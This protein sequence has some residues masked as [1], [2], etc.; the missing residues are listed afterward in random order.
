MDY[1]PINIKIKNKKC[2][3][4]GAGA[5]A[6]RKIQML[7]KAGA[8]IVCVALN[9]D[10]NIQLM[11]K[12][13]VIIKQDIY[14]YVDD[15]GLD[16]YSLIISA[17]NDDKLAQYIFNLAKLKN[18]LV[19]TVDNKQLCNYISPAIVDRNPIIISI[20]SSGVAPVL[21]RKIRESIEKI[22]P[23]KLGRLAQYAE[24][25]REQV[26]QSISTML[27]RRKFWESFFDST[28]GSKIMNTGY[29][30]N[31]NKLVNE[32]SEGSQNKGEVF[33]VGAG[34]GDPE[35][36]T[37]KAL[38][39]MQQA[40]VV[41]Y[42]RLISQEIIDL[43]RRDAE[44]INVGKSM[45]N[46]M[47]KQ[48][49]TNQL[50]IEQ[51]LK[52]KRV[53]RLKGGDP[54]VFGRGGEEIQALRKAGISYQIV[55]GITAAIGCASYAGIPLTH[56]DYAQKVVFVTAHCKNS[57]D[58]LDWSSIAQKKQTLVV[59]MGLMKS[60][61]LV[62]NLIANGQN[63]L[64]DVAVVENGTCHNQRVFNGRLYDLPG[65]IKRNSIESPALLIIGEVAKLGNELAWFQPQNQLKSSVNMLKIA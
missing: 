9:I 16:K 31:V 53:C 32:F 5:V 18:I 15:I 64:T 52:G 11:E 45:G 51:A 60:Q 54:F 28:I 26:K 41:F 24:T 25:I 59:Y 14:Q 63:R 42:D 56:R 48:E 49:D 7:K 62:D 12:S 46:H 19:N 21:A 55:P 65:L 43:V 61:Y 36:L 58:T 38:R 2:L 22:I 17:T 13:I 50:L 33:L 30:P 39:V 6:F 23:S 10:K 20:S 37:I 57:I 27:L 44:L 3:V 35:L 1:L 4:F 47:V 29:K 8:T 40:D 34:P